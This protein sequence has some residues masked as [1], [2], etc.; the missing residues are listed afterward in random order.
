M[1]H[2]T[3]LLPRSGVCEAGQALYQLNYIPSP[4]QFFFYFPETE[5]QVLAVP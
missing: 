1:T 5:S 2:Y 3:W 4:K